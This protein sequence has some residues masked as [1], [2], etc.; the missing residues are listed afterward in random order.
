MKKIL[1]IL[2]TA[3]FV[4]TSWT[5]E[6]EASNN[7]QLDQSQTHVFNFKTGEYEE[8]Q[9]R[10]PVCYICGNRM[11]SVVVEKVVDVYSRPCTHGHPGYED[12]CKDVHR[13]TEARCHTCGTWK[14]MSSTYLRTD[15]FCDWNI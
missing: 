12:I 11:D 3:F 2:F 10:M 9:P 13:V 6:A 4:T 5:F 7:H 8:I 14:V 1:V 15:V